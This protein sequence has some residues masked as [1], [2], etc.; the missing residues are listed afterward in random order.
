MKQMKR[1]Q[2]AVNVKGQLLQSYLGVGWSSFREQT[3]GYKMDLLKE[4]E[5][6]W[7]YWQI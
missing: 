5:R 2:G 4:D 1:V 6:G 3:L 7:N